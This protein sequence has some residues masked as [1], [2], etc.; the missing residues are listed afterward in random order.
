MQ[1]S[2]SNIGSSLIL[3]IIL[4]SLACTA[5]KQAAEDREDKTGDV[6]QDTANAQDLT[7]LKKTLADTRSKLSDVYTSQKHDLPDF[8]LA[9]DSSDESLNSNPFDGYRIQIISTRD[10]PRADSVAN[11]F[12]TWSDSTISGYTAKAYVFFRQPYYKVHVGDFQDRGPANR[13]SQLIKH[14]YPDA[15]VVHDRINPENVPTDTT[16]FSFITPGEKKDSDVKQED[17]S[18]QNKQN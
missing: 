16:T 12:R 18:N 15:W 9:Q 2:F 13:F 11:K 4:L 10:Q 14:R 17:T 3:L 5:T 6:S 7:S 1:F 8:F